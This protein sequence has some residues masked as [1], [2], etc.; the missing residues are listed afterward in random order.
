MPHFLR[1]GRH[2]EHLLAIQIGEKKKLRE[3]N[4]ARREF[5]AEMQH[6]ASLH[7]QYNVGEPF[8][9]RPNLIAR[10]SRRRGKRSRIQ[11]D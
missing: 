6:K 5:L 7:F 9:I 11:G 8:G 10:D 2:R 1:N 4:V 3:R